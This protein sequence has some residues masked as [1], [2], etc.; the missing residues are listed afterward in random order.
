MFYTTFDNDSKIYFNKGDIPNL[1]YENIKEL[2]LENCKLD[3]Y[4]FIKKCIKLQILD[5]SNNNLTN[6]D[7]DLFKYNT[8]LQYL[9]LNNNKLTNLNKDLFK[10]NTQLQYLDL[11]YNK[12]TNLDKDLFKYNTQLQYLYLNNNKLT[13]LDKDLF[14]YNTQLQNLYLNN[15]K[16]TNL[17]KD[18]FKYNTLLQTLWLFNNKLTNLDKD[19]FSGLTQLQALDLAD[20][21]NLTNLDKD[22]FKY[23]TLLQ[24][25]TLSNNN[26][27]NLDKDLF[28][29]NTQLQNLFLYN[30]KLNLLP[31]S[32]IN[33]NRLKNLD[34]QNN[35]I[36]YIPPNLQRFLNRLN[37]IDNNLQVY[38][39]SQ[40]VHNHSIQE[41]I[42][43]S[44]ENILNIP[45]NIN[46]YKL[47]QE[48]LESKMNE[49]SKR[50]LLEYCQDTSIHTVLKI[51][52][53]EALLHILEF[54]NLECSEH[55][56][57]IYCII[58]TE[59][60][61]AECKCFTGRISRLINCLNG[62]TPL[63]EIKIPDN[64]AISNIIVM[65]KQNYSGDNEEE[66]KDE[67]KKEL[68][69]RGYNEGVINT[70]IEYVELD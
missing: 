31:I 7:K 69:G 16:L 26:L 63:V 55:K 24:N 49:R 62:F 1:P 14:K 17:D 48:L 10:Y 57:E 54:I 38:N 21:N 22:L 6:I 65:L 9:Y 61:D 51:N 2:Y 11:S 36:E 52:F 5:L 40:N 42:K 50:L 56:E 3:N 15:N 4:D 32:I 18:L 25:L 37:Q 20:N 59:I 60:Q 29:Y 13:N 68:L 23:N 19:I 39:D 30:N 53:E 44:L 33:L 64:M 28:K 12:L 43:T 27:T 8:Q 58:D 70:Y 45:K 46:K 67:V 35:E 34:Y 66:L 41:G 47:T